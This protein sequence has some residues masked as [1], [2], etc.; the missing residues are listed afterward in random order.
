MAILQ[1]SSPRCLADELRTADESLTG[2]TDSEELKMIVKNIFLRLVLGIFSITI[3]LGAIKM[4]L[5]RDKRSIWGDIY[6]ACEEMMKWEQTG[7]NTGR[8]ML[9]LGFLGIIGGLIAIFFGFRSN[10][11]SLM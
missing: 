4:Y 8:I 1:F 9:Y 3:G 7:W 6:R 2:P 10:V 5:D 11:L